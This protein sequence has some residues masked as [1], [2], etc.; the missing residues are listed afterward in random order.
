MTEVR[1][2][3][4]VVGQ[5]R[6]VHYLKQDVEHVGVRFFDL[7]EQEHR[8]RVLAHVFDQLAALVVAHVARRR[9]DQAR[10]RVLFHVLAHVVSHERDTKGLGQLFGEFRLAD[11]RWP[12]K[13]ER[14]NRP[15]GAT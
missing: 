6:V 5:D 3:P 8:V 15:V 12:R 10:H 14:A 4:L 2:T 1:L 13:E 11:P 7:V 9:A